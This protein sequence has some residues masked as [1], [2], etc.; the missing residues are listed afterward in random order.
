[1]ISLRFPS[2][3][4]AL[5]VLTFDFFVEGRKVTKNLTKPK[6]FLISYL[7]VIFLKILYV[8]CNS[9]KQR[10]SF[11]ISFM[12][13]FSSNKIPGTFNYFESFYIGSKHILAHSA[14]L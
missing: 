11:K 12:C 14:S 10:K 2:E 8:D 6:T 3:G 5:S 7:K 9:S 4:A 1:M 13:I